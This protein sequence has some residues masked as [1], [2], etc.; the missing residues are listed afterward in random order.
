[1]GCTCSL[2][3]IYIDTTPSIYMEDFS[4]KLIT[5]IISKKMEPPN[6]FMNNIYFIEKTVHDIPTISPIRSILEIPN[7]GGFSQNSEFVSSI[8][9]EKLF[10]KYLSL[11]VVHVYTETQI[12]YK[13][14]PLGKHTRQSRKTD[15]VLVLNNGKKVA[16]EV[17]RV[18]RN[19]YDPRPYQKTCWT[20]NGKIDCIKKADLSA[21]EA[22]ENVLDEYCWDYHFLHFIVSRREVP[23]FYKIIKQHIDDNPAFIKNFTGILVSYVN[24]YNDWVFY[25]DSELRRFGDIYNNV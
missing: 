21:K 5:S 10:Q 15:Y 2:S 18:F 4:R 19:R 13:P 1:M 22:N 12:K 25:D 6:V 16:I 17:K 23:N 14:V 9:F 3:K 20:D 8:I 24:T 7:E 11:Y